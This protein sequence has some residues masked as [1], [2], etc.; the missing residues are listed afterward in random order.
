MADAKISALTA[1]TTPTSDDLIV[2][3]NDPGG[4][5]ANRKVTLANAVTKAHG[6]SDS[7]IVG[8][9]GGVL[10]SGTD[11]AVVDGGT[12]ASDAATA[13]TN[14]GLAIGSDVQAYDAQL[15]DVAG[16]TPTDN[17]VIIGNGT[18]FVAE[19]GATL[20]T[21]LGLTIGTDVQAYDADLTTI[22]GLTATSNNIIQSV[23]S[24]WASRTP[25]QVTAT[26][27][28]M[29]GDSGSGGTKGLVPAPSAGD[30]AAGKYLKADG[31][32]TAISASPGGSDTQIQFNDG[33]VFGGNS[34]LVFDKT[35]SKLTLTST[36]NSVILGN[37]ASTVLPNTIDYSASSTSTLW[38]LYLTTKN[39]N[40]GASAGAIAVGGSVVPNTNTTK[41]QIGISGQYVPANP[42]AGFSSISRAVGTE[43]GG[44][45]ASN[46][47]TT[48][49]FYGIF[50]SAATVVSG[51]ITRNYAGGFGSKVLMIGTGSGSG[52]WWSSADGTAADA[53]LYRSA[54]GILKTDT[55]L[56][57][58]T[59]LTIGTLGGYLFGTSG[60]V[61]AKSATTVTS[62]LDAVVGDSGSGGTK[63]LVPAPAAGD[64][65]AGKYLKADGTWA[66]VSAGSVEG[67]AVL[68]T[69]ET[70]GV[71]FLREDGDGT[72]SWQTIT[73][74]G[75]ALVANPLSQFAATTSSQLAGVIS[76]ET[77]SGA[78]VFATSPTLVTPLLGT[79]TSGVL[80]NCTGT[81]SG[82]T[83]GNVT[84]NAN[85]TGPITSVGNA[86]SIASQT[87]T[88]TKFVVDTSPTLV[89]PVLGVAT[90]TS[91]NK[92]T[93]T[94]PAT[95]ATLTLIDG[96]TLTGPS[97]TG[98]IAT[99]AGTETF[100]NKTLTSPTLTT[101][102]LGTPAS[103]T[104]TSCTGLPI[105]TG[106]SGLGTGVAT[107]LATPSSA[108]L[109]SAVTDETG[110]GA[111]VF[112][113][114]PTLTTPTL[115]GAVTLDENASI[116]LDPAGSADGKY[117]GIT[118]TGTGGATIAF[119]DLVTLDK[120][121]SRWELV[122]I[123]VAAAATGDARGIIGIAV[124]SSTD[125]NPITVLLH[126][127]V[128][129]DAN[130]PALTIGAAVYAST[131][132]DVVVTQPT[133]TDYVIRIVGFAMTADELYFNPSQDYITHT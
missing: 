71:K 3:V 46:F 107:F 88:G 85:L 102:T 87:G 122:D 96:T 98:T 7:T 97:A 45:H 37:S 103:G 13:R 66:T 129:A 64:A 5:P 116:A 20:K 25:T 110:S 121:D 117:S 106:V 48:T 83:A 126:G 118:V 30:A 65:A 111:L 56:T 24:A 80:T 47:L 123:S 75:D 41:T 125:G 73:G 2:T 124:T 4:T 108:N 14:L 44:Y 130:F 81:A 28:A 128:R 84:T 120:D 27:D 132:G 38:G 43:G 26:L 114:S 31:T 115:S 54:T 50:G 21:S 133:T 78:L 82:L 23:S 55:A 58:G 70:G 60:A 9:S 40:G 72:C 51:T 6:L 34:G 15:A 33:G 74:G 100:T 101:P 79:P 68:S 39:T 1:D 90:A 119:G 49:D 16:L 19:S 113:T 10:T 35:L 127:I 112:G 76:D 17:A 61:S 99:L 93:L 131:T 94:A 53:V 69:G 36:G 8:V 63:G 89:T 92:V 42:G 91:I 22:A 32:W 105:S 29:V 67:T 95:S 77:G 86:T 62:E 11:V 109:I 57:V 12:G 18:N 104:L 52:L 59:T